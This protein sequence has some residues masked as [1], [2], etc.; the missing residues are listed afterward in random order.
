[1]SEGDIVDV[2]RMW[3]PRWRGL[4][5]V[6][7]CFLALAACGRAISPS[8]SEARLVPIEV[9]PVDPQ[10]GPDPR[11]AAVFQG[12]LWLMGSGGSVV[13]FG[14]DDN[15]RKVEFAE[16]VIA[17]T[18][19]GDTLWLLRKDIR[20]EPPAD[21]T[22]VVSRL[23]GGSH[24]DSAPLH[25]ADPPRGLIVDGEMPIIIATQRLYALRPGSR[26]WET[27]APRGMHLFPIDRISAAAVNG[28]V[29]IA[30]NRGEFGGAFRRV[31]LATGAT[32]DLDSQER[33]CLDLG[34]T[35][36]NDLLPDPTSPGC[37]LI[38][39]GYTHMGALDGRILRLC[40]NH[41]STVFEQPIQI[42]VLWKSELRTQPFFGLAA[43]SPSG[44]WAVAPGAL[45]RFDGDDAEP[46]QIP[47]PKQK[48]IF[49]FF[50]SRDVPGLI[51][52]YPD[53]EPP[54]DTVP[55][56]VPLD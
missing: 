37:L 39:V 41:I 22:F 25:T 6:C 43:A 3:W 36:I 29:Y 19:S 1:M 32:E 21:G 56:I 8:L 4:L 47:L 23:A 10:I 53:G 34:C 33:Q 52:L 2:T 12:R 38:S 11:G 18:K 42:N 40:G 20:A 13:S 5:V 30:T 27:R 44:F 46:E 51:L 16:G 14:L 17:M 28:D 24:E 9:P 7:L 50:M 45:Y 26:S 49:R 55:A 31:A 35:S 54:T 15:S 48:F